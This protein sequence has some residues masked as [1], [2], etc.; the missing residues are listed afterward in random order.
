MNEKLTIYDTTLRDGTQAENFN[1]SVEDKVRITLKLDELG[2]DFIE[3]G[4]PGASPASTR[5]FEEI[6]NYELKHAVVTA[7]GSTR[8]FSKPPEEDPNLA[9]LLAAKTRAITIFG[10]S[11]DIHVRDALRIE[12][13]DN[14]Q[15]IEDS[16]AYLRPQVE[17][18]FYDAEHF[19]DGYK[20]NP[21]YALQT[22]ERAVAGGAQCLVLCDTNG[23]TLPGEVATIIGEVSRHLNSLTVKTSVAPR[24]AEGEGGAELPVELGI[25]AHNDSE[26]AVANSLVAVSLGVRQVQGTINGIGERC[27]NANLTSIMPGLA[28]KMKHYFP[29]AENLHKLTETSRFVSELGNLAHHKYQPYVGQAAFAHKGGIHVSAVKRNPL[30]YEHIDP[31]R[32]GNIR[33]ILISDQAGRSNV[34]HKAKKFGIDLDSKDPLVSSILKKLKELETQ[35]FQYEGAEASFELLMRKALGTCKEYFHLLG[36]KVISQKDPCALGPEEE[37]VEEATIRLEVGGE[38]VHTA[39]LGHGPVN[40]LDNALRKALYGFY[41]QLEQVELQDYKVR[42]LASE[43]GTGARVRVLIESSDDDSTWG[44]VG[45]SHDIIEASWQ[46]LVDSITYKLMKDERQRQAEG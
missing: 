17:F 4:W 20:A 44:T 39:A 3:G 43:H 29:A 26:C 32:V 22:L 7:F 30:T 24:P 13:E 28:L 45:V 5:Y 8:N 40:A 11:W 9:A 42:V 36:Y 16:L 37:V 6:R 38:L 21:Q 12:L 46:A 2:I 31:E 1:L 41:P 27:G 23:G 34:L 33:R 25:H 14:L 35:G 19:F 18:L 10:K 15:I